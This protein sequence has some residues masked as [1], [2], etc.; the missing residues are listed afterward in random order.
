ML[1]RKT[2]T[3]MVGRGSTPS[4]VTLGKMARQFASSRFHAEN[5]KKAPRRSGAV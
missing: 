5:D 3:A 4:Q 1:Y 2:P